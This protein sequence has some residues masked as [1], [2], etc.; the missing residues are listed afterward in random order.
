MVWTCSEE[1]LCVNWTM[2][3]RT[4]KDVEDGVATEEERRRSQIW[5]RMRQEA[6][7]SGVGKHGP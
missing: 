5:K 6:I 4:E 1:R 7:N 2:M 3:D